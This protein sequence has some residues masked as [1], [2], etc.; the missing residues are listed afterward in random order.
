MIQ[1]FNCHPYKIVFDKSFFPIYNVT[2]MK[3]KAKCLWLWAGLF[4]LPTLGACSTTSPPKENQTALT[5]SQAVYYKTFAEVVQFIKNMEAII[6]EQDF[7]AWKKQC[8]AAYLS[9][10]SNRGVLR[11]LSQKPNLK[12]RSLVLRSLDDYFIHVFIPSRQGT[13]LDKLEF[14]SPNRVK[15]I[16]VVSD[17]PYVVY[18]LEKDENNLW[19]IGVW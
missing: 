13:K 15:A 9:M 12:E 17:V 8:T 5:V 6:A 14:I 4:F 1:K 2:L 10:Y 19:K 11:E 18:F 3:R 7:A 16:T